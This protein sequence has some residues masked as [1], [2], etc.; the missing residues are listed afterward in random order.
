[1][2]QTETIPALTPETSGLSAETLMVMPYFFD[3]VA[4]ADT[5]N[6]PLGEHIKRVGQMLFD[7][8]NY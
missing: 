1:M 7:R 5:T 3:V 6:T 4:L 8:N 2:N